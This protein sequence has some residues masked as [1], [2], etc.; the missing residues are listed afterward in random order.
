MT[1]QCEKQKGPVI[2][3]L[4]VYQDLFSG[5]QESCCNS[6][7]QTCLTPEGKQFWLISSTP[8][9]CH[10]SSR[11]LTC[12]SG[13]KM[14]E[15]LH[16]LMENNVYSFFKKIYLCYMQLNLP[17]RKTEGFPQGAVCVGVSL[18]WVVFK[19]IYMKKSFIFQPYFPFWVLVYIPIQW[20]IWKKYYGGETHSMWHVSFH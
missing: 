7:P 6:S 15:I 20:H 1:L 11:F 13:K 3:Y 19:S 16:K 12:F 5:S 2:Y 10:H 14:E 4:L 17:D 18:T 9:R 8:T